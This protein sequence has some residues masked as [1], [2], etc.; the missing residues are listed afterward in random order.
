MS[1]ECEIKELGIENVIVLETQ[2][3]QDFRGFVNKIYSEALLKKNGIV[4]EA[5]EELIIQSKQN[6]LRGLHFQKKVGQAKLVRVINGKI[7][8]VV[9][10]INKNSD[11]FGEWVS[12]YLENDGKT[13]YIPETCAFG[14]LAL[15][16]TILSCKCGSEFVA[17]YSNGIIWNDKHIAIDWPLDNSRIGPILSEKDKNLQS[18]R[19][20]MNNES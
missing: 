2:P 10:D 3:I 8:A 11:T 9:L 5:K 14:S 15:E 18:L 16:D 4:F 17:E 6:V 7:Y 13:L 12:V 20:Y 19:E 1:R